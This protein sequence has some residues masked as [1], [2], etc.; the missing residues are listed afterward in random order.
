MITRRIAL[1]GGTLAALGITAP[2]LATKGART[3]V[4]ETVPDFHVP[5]GACDSHVHVLADPA[6]F[7][8]AADRDYTP[9]PATAESLMQ[10]LQTL[11]LSRVVVVTPDAYGD[12]NAATLDAIQKCGPGRARGVVWL[13]EEGTTAMFAAMKAQGIAG[14]RVSLNR[15]ALTNPT[16]P[17]NLKAKFEIAERFGWHLDF[18]SP[19]DVIAGLGAQ[20]GACPVPVVL[21]TFAWLAG[22]LQQPGI[23]T[24]LSLMKSGHVHIKLSEPYRL[25]SDGPDYPDLRPLVQAIVSTNPDRVLWGSGWPHVSGP[26]PGRPKTAPTPNMPIDDGHLLNLLAR[27]VPDDA[28]RRKILV[29]N[30]ARLYRF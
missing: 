5:D 20:L 6:R 24:I 4:A 9:A 28:T 23:D 3:Q 16:T 7:P 12:V 22:G 8:M 10:M 25:S 14:F 11:H 30:P 27:W 29:D 21:D 2:H 19:A 26:V 18:I 15:A 17:N 1:M 13:P